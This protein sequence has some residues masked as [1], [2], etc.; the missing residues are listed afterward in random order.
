MTFAGALLGNTGITIAGAIVLAVGIAL[1]IN[2][3]SKID[4]EADVSQKYNMTTKYDTY[5]MPG[6]NE[7]MY[8]TFNSNYDTQYIVK[9][10][11]KLD[12]KF[13]LEVKYFE[14]YYDYFVKK[15]TNNI[16]VSLS[17]DTR[18]RISSYI[19]DIKENKIYKEDELSRYTVKITI[20][21]KDYERL[22]IEN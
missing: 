2:E 7:K 17:K 8:I 22:V 4:I 6:K 13:K 16:Y 12:G 20:S 21:E 3:V 15:T 1:T 11:N 5:N 18:D 14:N 19:D 9:Y 10:D